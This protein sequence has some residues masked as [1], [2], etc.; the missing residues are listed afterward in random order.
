MAPL[1]YNFGLY[2]LAIYLAGSEHGMLVKYPKPNNA[3]DG[4][5]KVFSLN[6]NHS[7]YTN[8][9]MR[10]YQMAKPIKYENSQHC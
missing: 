5:I 8:S 10:N 4:P 9:L 7:I 3:I 2:N 1:I 6:V